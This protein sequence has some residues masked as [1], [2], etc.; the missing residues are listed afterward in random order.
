MPEQCV[1]LINVQK[2]LKKLYGEDYG[3]RIRQKDHGT[4]VILKI[5]DWVEGDFLNAEAADR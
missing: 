4:Q 3:L 1:G 2:R 5:P